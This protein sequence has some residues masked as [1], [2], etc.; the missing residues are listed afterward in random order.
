[1]DKVYLMTP[2]PT[3]VPQN[4]LLSQAQEIVHHRKPQYREVFAHVLESLKQVFCTKEDVLL[5][6]SSGTGAMEAAVA[7]ILSKEDKA[8]VVVG[9]KFGE[10]WAQLCNAFGVQ[11]VCINIEWGHA[12]SAEQIAE[13]LKE[14]A[15]IKAVFTTLVETSTATVTDIESIAKITSGTETLLVVDAVSALC[16]EEL[17][18]DEWGVDVAV[19]GSQKGLMMPPGLS[20]AAVS[21]KAWEAVKVSDLPKYYFSFLSAKKA[22]QKKETPFTPPVSLIF[23]LKEALDLIIQEGIEEVIKRHRLLAEATREGV[24]AMGL[25]LLSSSP[26]NAVTAV[27]CDEAESVIKSMEKD[28][29]IV[30]ASGQEHLKGRIFRIAHMGYVQQTD[31]LHTLSALEMVLHSLG[32]EGKMGEGTRAALEVFG[33]KDA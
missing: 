14:N 19:A 30:L 5:F 3:Q 1:M 33:G 8:L 21:K 20:F 13:A 17:R 15:P 2:G 16:T 7:N 12:V 22:L 28:F 24:K 29:G 27:L 18:F 11:T 23:A 4:V 25:A 10:R 9:G 31:I 32:K 6:C 26:S